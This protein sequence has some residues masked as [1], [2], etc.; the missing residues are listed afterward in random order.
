MITKLREG[1]T[2]ARHNKS[3][4]KA[5]KIMEEDDGS[6][7]EGEIEVDDEENGIKDLVIDVH[8]YIKSIGLACNNCL[9]MRMK[10]CKLHGKP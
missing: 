8:E 9:I 4:G 6:K 5:T 2:E 10:S 7:E 1:R 3:K